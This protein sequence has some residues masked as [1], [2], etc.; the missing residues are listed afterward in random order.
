MEYLK[1]V[2]N[3]LISNSI[4][5]NTFIECQEDKDCK[6]KVCT[7]GYCGKNMLTQLLEYQIK[8]FYCHI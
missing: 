1:E 2:S 6:S 3:S 8:F 4:L 5:S 7:D